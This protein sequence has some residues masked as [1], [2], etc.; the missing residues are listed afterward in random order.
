MDQDQL[1]VASS[2]F[3][4][5]NSLSIDTADAYLLRSDNSFAPFATPSPVQASQ[6]V[7]AA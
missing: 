7:R 2:A 1:I 6:P 5:A 3:N 4:P